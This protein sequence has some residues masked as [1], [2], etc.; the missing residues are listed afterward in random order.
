MSEKTEAKVTP[1]SDKGDFT[2]IT[3]KPDLKRFKMEK[4][5]EDHEAI[6]IKRAYD[7]AGVIDKRV[8]VYLNES[9][10][11]INNFED[12]IKLYMDTEENKE[13]PFIHYKC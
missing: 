6:F 10:I 4:I 3:F 11:P 8:T 2:K 5:D 12:Y 7:M 9:K 1:S 13:L